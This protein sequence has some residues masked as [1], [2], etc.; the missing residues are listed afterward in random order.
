MIKIENITAGYGD[1]AVLKNISLNIEKG[2]FVGII[3]SSGAGKST[4]L[5]SLIGKV[6]LMS[7]M[8]NVL[9]YDMNTVSKRNLM[10]LRSEVGFVFQGFNLVNRLNVLDN[11]M[12]GLLPEI[13]LFRAMFKLYSNDKYEKVYNILNIVG[14]TDKAVQRCDQLSGGQ[15]QRVAIARAFAQNPKMILADEPVAALDPRSAA[16]VMNT[17]KKIN[18]NFGVTVI[19]NLHQI[20]VAREYCERVVGINAGEV[21]FD[22]KIGELTNSVI[23]KIYRSDETQKS[24][25][26][27]EIDPLSFVSEE[28][29]VI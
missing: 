19:A 11:V 5:S 20:E 28:G 25:T 4:L 14:L 27:E 12:T 16:N 21:I 24:T 18:Q 9:D 22:G 2:E 26:R 17:L 7:G 8:M 15:R 6:R 10:K 1:Y 3:G 13:P 23:D 29:M